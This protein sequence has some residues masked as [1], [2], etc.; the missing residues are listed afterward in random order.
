ME[1]KSLKWEPVVEVGER[2]SLIS[3]VRESL[4]CRECRGS[5][6]EDTEALS[7]PA[8]LVLPEGGRTTPWYSGRR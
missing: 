3:R 6:I 5:S 7:L 4:L 1:P 8:M 2:R